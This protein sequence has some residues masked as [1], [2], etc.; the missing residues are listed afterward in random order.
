MPVGMHLER[1]RNHFLLEQ[2]IGIVFAALQLGNDHGSF[3]L[4]TSTKPRPAAPC[5]LPA[6]SRSIHYREAF[7]ASLSIITGGFGRTGGAGRHSL[8]KPLHFP[9]KYWRGLCTVADVSRRISMRK[10]F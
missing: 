8:K 9:D 3:R 7:A 1:R 5:A 6:P 2:L 4:C 10:P